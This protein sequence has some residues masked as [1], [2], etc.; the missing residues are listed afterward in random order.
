MV[1]KVLKAT[2]KV[3]LRI[4]LFL[5]ISYLHLAPCES[6]RT[7]R[8]SANTA[9]GSMFPSANTSTTGLT[10]DRCRGHGPCIGIAD[11]DTL[12][13]SKTQR[14]YVRVIDD[15]SSPESRVVG[16]CRG[17][18]P[19][20][21][22]LCSGI[23]ANDPTAAGDPL[24]SRDRG[25]SL[26]T[27]SMNCDAFWGYEG[28]CPHAVV[29][30]TN[31]RW[32]VKTCDWCRGHGPST[33]LFYTDT[34]EEDSVT[35]DSP[36][37]TQCK[38]YGSSASSIAAD[39]LHQNS[40]RCPRVREVLDD[41]I[42]SPTMCAR[43]GGRILDPSFFCSDV[44]ADE[45]ATMRGLRRSR[46]RRRGSSIGSVDGEARAEAPSRS[47]SWDEARYRLK[48]R[49]RHLVHHSRSVSSANVRWD[50]KM[51]DR[52]RGHSPNA[53]LFY[54]DRYEDDGVAT[55]DP[56]VH[57]C[58]GY[59][60]SASSIDTDMLRRSRRGCPWL[61]EVVDDSV[62]GFT[63]C[64][65][66][67]GRD[68]GTS[69]F[70][71]DMQAD[72][73]AS[74]RSLRRSRCR[75]HGP[76]IGSVD[77]AARADDPRRSAYWDETR[78]RLKSR[79]GHLLHHSRSE[80]WTLPRRT[81]ALRSYL[82][83][84]C[85][86]INYRRPWWKDALLLRA[87]IYIL[88]DDFWTCWSQ[89]LHWTDA[90]KPTD[91]AAI[92]YLTPTSGEVPVD[93]STAYRHGLAVMML[94]VHAQGIHTPYA[95]QC[96]LLSAMTAYTVSGSALFGAMALVWPTFGK[97]ASMTIDVTTDAVHTEVQRCQPFDSR[98]S[99]LHNPD[100][101][102]YMN[103]VL[104]AL[105]SLPLV[106][107]Y[108]AD[109]S[110]AQLI[111]RL[112]AIVCNGTETVAQRWVRAR[113]I[114][115][116]E[117]EWRH[118]LFA[119]E[120]A[121]AGEHDHTTH[122]KPLVAHMHRGRQEDA[123]EFLSALLGNELDG[124][125][126]LHM[127]FRGEV[128]PRIICSACN[129][130]RPLTREAFRVLPLSLQHGTG[131][132]R[133]L[134]EAWKAHC[135][136]GVMSDD[137]HFI[138]DCG[139]KRSPL[140]RAHFNYMPRVLCLQLKR[141]RH[142]NR[143]GAVLLNHSVN[144]PEFYT[145]AGHDYEL[146]AVVFHRGSTPNSG[147]YWTCAK[148]TVNREKVWWYSNDIQ[149]RRAQAPEPFLSSAADAGHSYLLFY[150]ERAQSRQDGQPP[151]PTPVDIR[152][153]SLTDLS[154]AMRKYAINVDLEPCRALSPGKRELF[155]DP[156]REH[157][158]SLYIL[159]SAVPANESNIFRKRL[160][161]V[162]LV[163]QLP[164]IV[165]ESP[166]APVV[167]I[168][169][170]RGRGAK[171]GDAKR[172]CSA[173]GKAIAEED[174]PKA[175]ANMPTDPLQVPHGIPSALRPPFGEHGSDGVIDNSTEQSFPHRVNLRRSEAEPQE[176]LDK[177]NARK[178]LW[179]NIFQ[180]KVTSSIVAERYPEHQ[181]WQ[182]AAAR[183]ADLFL[184]DRPTLPANPKNHDISF[185]EAEVDGELP[186]AHCA[187]R[188]CTWH[189]DS[190]DLPEDRGHWNSAATEAM[191]RDHAEHPCDE[192]LRRHVLETHAADFAKS[193]EG[194]TDSFSHAWELYKAG[195]S[196][197]E[198]RAIPVVGPL[199]DR[200]LF[201][202]LA[203]VYNNHRTRSLICMICAQIKLDTG[204]SHS[205]IKFISGT[206]F[207]TLPPQAL[208]KNCS[209]RTFQERYA[210]AGSPLAVY[211]NLS[212]HDVENVSFQEWMLTIHPDWTSLW[213]R[214]GEGSAVELSPEQIS[215][216]EDLTCEP[217]LCCPED[218]EC[219]RSECKDRGMLCPRCRIPVCQDCQLHLRENQMNP[220]AI[221]ND[222][223][224]GYLTDFIYQLR[225][226]WMEKT[227][228]SPYWTGLTLFSIGARGHEGKARKRHKLDEAMYT[229]Q[230]RIAFKGQLFSAP[231]D[232]RSVLEQIKEMETA[233]RIVDLPV[234]G[235]ILAKRVKV[236][237]AAG[238]VD[239]N[240]LLREATVR[241]D[242]VVRLIQMHKD[243]GH[244]DYTHL[245]MPRV[246]ELARSL[247]STDEPQIPS[248]IAELLDNSEDEQLEDTTDKAAT[249]AERVYH[250]A[251]LQ[252]ELA[253]S[254]P[255]VLLSQRDSDAQKN[256]AASR[257]NALSTVTTLE[258]Q[259]GSNL[260]QQF[261]TEY[262][263]RVFSLTLPRQVGGPDFPGQPRR[264]RCFDDAPTLNLQ[265]YTAMMARR[266]EAQVR[267]DWDL[268]PGLQSLSFAS[269]V[270]RAVGISLQRGV[271][272]LEDA[273]E[274]EADDTQIGLAMKRLYELLHTGE[275]VD[276]AG[277]RKRLN[278]DIS[279][280]SRVI[281]LTPLQSAIVRNMFFMSARLA[282]TR[283]V[284]KHIGHMLTAARIAY[285]VPIF[286]T[287][288]PSERHSGLTVHLTRYRLGDPG[289][290]VAT[291]ELQGLAG[292]LYPSVLASESAR[293]ELPE[294][295]LRRTCSNR[296]PLCAVYA[297]V[298]MVRVVFA[299]LYGLRMCPICPDCER[300]HSPCMDRYG[301]SATALGGSAGRADAMIGAVEAQKAEGVLHLHLFLF[302]QM[303]MQ[304]LTLKEIANMF[305]K[306]VLS[307][308]TWKQY[309]NHVRPAAYPEYETFVTEREDVEK[310]WPAYAH[311]KELCRPPGNLHSLKAPGFLAKAYTPSPTQSTEESF[312]A[313]G[314]MVLAAEAQAMQHWKLEGDIYQEHYRRRLQFVQSHMNNHIHP[315]NVHTGE[316]VPLRSCRRKDRP[317]ETKCGFPVDEG[318]LL[319]A[320]R[321]ICTCFADV[322]GWTT[323]GPRS[324]VGS[325]F[326]A[327]NDAM[328]N[329]G[330]A[331]WLVWS[332]DNGD[333][334]F[335]H[336]IP[337]IPETHE[338]PMPLYHQKHSECVSAVCTLNMLYDLQAA[339]S[340]AAGYFG[341]YTSK[342]QD[343]GKKELQRLREALERKIDREH[344]K[345]LPKA[346]QEYSK[347]LL[348][349]LEAKSTV[350][351]AVENLNLA[352]HG[353]HADML[354]AECIRTF[355]SVSFP[356]ATLLRREEVETGKSRGASLIV[357][358]HHA[359]GEG[360]R[361][362]TTAP[363]DLMYG[364]RGSSHNVDLLSPYEMLRYWEMERILIPKRG[365]ANPTA[366]WTEV[367]KECARRFATTGEQT[368]MKAGVHYVAT[369]APGRILLP[370]LAVLHGLRHRWCWHRRPRP[371]VP[372]WNFA[373][374]PRN[375]L[376][377]EENCRLLSVYM[378]P[379]TLYEK[380][381]TVQTPLLTNLR[382]GNDTGNDAGSDR[383]RGRG[384][385]ID[386]G[387]DRRDG[388]SDIHRD[389]DKRGPDEKQFR[390]TT[391]ADD[392]TEGRGDAVIGDYHR[393][394]GHGPSTGGVVE[395]G[396]SG[397]ETDRRR[398]GR[399]PGNRKTYAAGWQQYVGGNVATEMQRRY[400]QNLVIATTARISTE[401]EETTSDESDFE[402][403]RS[404]RKI[405]DLSVAQKTIAGLAANDEDVGSIGFG[406]YGE[407]IAL[408]RSLWQTDRLTAE[409]MQSMSRSE[410]A[411][412]VSATSAKEA[413]TLHKKQQTQNRIAPF[414]GATQPTS[415]VRHQDY[416][417][418]FARWFETLK[419]EADQPNEKQMTVIE[420]VRNR[421]LT[422]VELIVAPRSL[423]CESG[424][425]KRAEDA[426][427]EPL[428]ALC[429]GE[430]GTGKS[431]V[432]KWIIR[433]F[434]EVME[435][436]HG[437]EFEC[438]A[439]Q[440]RVAF[441]MG[442]STLHGA[443]QI[444]IG[445]QSYSAMLEHTDID[446]LFT[447]NQHLRFV[448]FDE[449]FMI[450]DELLGTF[451]K[452]YQEAAP[453]SES[454]RYFARADGQ[455]RIFGGL[456]WCMFGDMSQLPP[457]PSSSAIF[458][459]PQGKARPPTKTAEEILE[460][461][462]T[463]KD[464]SLN[465]FVELTQQQ[466]TTDVWFRQLL[467]E[468]RVGALSDENYNFLMGLPTTHNG[469]WLSPPYQAA[470]LC[471]RPRC[472]NLHV[473]WR[474][475]AAQGTDWTTM[476]ALASE[477]LICR[478]ERERRCR[479]VT[480]HTEKVASQLF[481][482]AP[483]VHQNNQPKYHAMLLRAVEHAKRGF[484]TP[485][486]VRWIRAQDTPLKSSDVGRTPEQ[487]DRKL[488][489]FLQ[490][491]DQRTA[492]IPGLFVMY[493][494]APVRTT[495]KLKLSSEI[496]VL[497][498]TSGRI[499]GWELH[500]ADA[501]T[502]ND[503]EVFLQ[504]IPKVVF[505]QFAKVKWHLDGMPPGLL[506]IYPVDRTWV[507]NRD[508]DARVTRRGFT[509]VN[510][511]A[512][513]AFM[514]QGETLEAMLADCGD[515][516]EVVGLAE[517]LTCY[518]IL[519]RI[520]TADGLLL[521]RAFSK[522]LFQQGEPPGPKCLLEFL[523]SRFDQGT[524]EIV[525]ED[526]KKDASEEIQTKYV[527]LNAVFER[528][529]KQQGT[530]GVE[531]I[532][533]SCEQ[534]FPA[535]GYGAEPT[536][537]TTTM[538][539]CIAQGSWRRCTA[540]REGSDPQRWKA[541]F[542]LQVCYD[543]SKSMR[544]SDMETIQMGGDVSEAYRCKACTK[545][546]EHFM[547]TVCNRHKEKKEFQERVD[548]AQT[549][550][551]CNECRTCS[552]CD[553]FYKDARHFLCNTRRCVRCVEHTCSVCKQSQK[554]EAFDAKQLDN[555]RR[556]IQT[557][558]K[559]KTCS[560]ARHYACAAPPCQK[561][562][563]LMP[564]SSFPAETVQKAKKKGAEF[565]MICMRC[566]EL[567]Y[568]SGR[569][570][571]NTY[572]CA[573]CMQDLGHQRFTSR[574]LNDKQ[575]RPYS[576]LCCKDCRGI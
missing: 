203:Y 428:R 362:W 480:K 500:A 385:S 499:V 331:A 387:S 468:C 280:L 13:R 509:L 435:W 22:P 149:Q 80:R 64:A 330:P 478:H 90:L 163:S 100:N 458:V 305:E 382:S 51:R 326:S 142:D 96:P 374:L 177:S 323:T 412:T 270:N 188:G 517:M 144:I 261:E 314:D 519:S 348:K 178:A 50:V 216:G 364:F 296:D 322:F 116:T 234:T 57:P 122:Y 272:K 88:S 127:L 450:P 24:P 477:C 533:S 73:N 6:M 465:F 398:Q 215:E 504:Y 376:P 121:Y 211:G 424:G 357:A 91:V 505:V 429:V 338:E 552:G 85:W 62:C 240:N 212:N 136:A 242:V 472:L 158:R 396:Y 346:F 265:S 3:E 271:R 460:A 467:N 107:T 174:S 97:R 181:R 109:A 462:W 182:D 555:N 558:L 171:G 43:R 222:N 325:V 559:C 200:R 210:R 320:P 268:L 570:G 81:R 367:G 254:R 169:T 135:A 312:P 576:S 28:R 113:N 241:Y 42:C 529:R 381:A 197:L 355:P 106:R 67:G 496:T 349:D 440:N 339:Q 114:V 402:Y 23:R 99:S 146:H 550:R 92:L 416:A 225:V 33:G 569:N 132:H 189:L 125:L 352:I 560:E 166:P 451:M 196:I 255:M 455:F 491:H 236:S 8:R 65:R 193:C 285:G 403:I 459:P 148:H 482:H 527:E 39:V 538:E 275:Y 279:K 494:G 160:E 489:R 316:R 235:E 386:Q 508:T 510:D 243:A 310:A 145:F 130:E 38:E 568:S 315:L 444:K 180:M 11:E 547:C 439:F 244:S 187:C 410:C 463:A 420:R 572:R 545:G 573:R 301:S 400:I 401:L 252:R 502:S 562:T 518:V 259:T 186:L 276:D 324:V 86:Y 179:L 246:R 554:A 486:Q 36:T 25:C 336:K 282:G 15:G 103:S 155:L 343:I 513:T 497:K 566:V 397:D 21:G 522:R 564:E 232:W 388:T 77:G 53:G 20:I 567:G 408:G 286:M 34:Y 198:R 571:T 479:L 173:Y 548:K 394:R 29:S 329:A 79:T 371:F 344:R 206:W 129:Q 105:W 141:W 192:L 209:M 328:L 102:C 52:C 448:L 87:L 227:V 16:L 466:R 273:H 507:V 431:R 157:L 356:A 493:V 351:T 471:R 514:M 1:K 190:A 391:D 291:P 156:I 495:E 249:P 421:L 524:G 311:T 544:R 405:G 359:R 55:G 556:T 223:F 31:S 521:L 392:D 2:K 257:E 354:R 565:V 413:V 520:K 47:G 437:V 231:M 27:V 71:S 549:I 515:V 153:A 536:D 118:L 41:F 361:T 219:T 204:G 199:I 300:T 263:P 256:V 176:T 378:R 58:R 370:D 294:Y 553:T 248:E 137:T 76:S 131:L 469:C 528:N 395:D 389:G 365:E 321:L 14:P 419:T 164:C 563:A 532:C 253:R 484:S 213:P 490:L 95:W 70:C 438:V 443:G 119:Y 379:W 194:L 317:K 82:L 436:K 292:Y 56:T 84:L 498:H 432:I 308:E 9:Y 94:V 461:F 69:F 46:C 72:G 503:F 380:D 442:G 239:L 456:N 126:P 44:H 303:A 32:D 267:W 205:A 12:S 423:R 393:C 245:D 350:R 30:D 575:K 66:R 476:Q 332:G 430:P 251:N 228:I 48:S 297:F 457:I 446:S 411:Y 551:R 441:A 229:S 154:T 464:N 534:A 342:M 422:E 417:I 512:S 333:I 390:N 49:T 161:I 546:K 483:Y 363:F 377:A 167:P 415:S 143:T 89:C 289:I 334:K 168:T 288:T 337:I 481:L 561:K 487:V 372:V 313:A 306:G 134:D 152:R 427:E 264:R 283:Q 237:V 201:Q 17:H 183:I 10:L 506:P 247:N 475:F 535:P 293:I 304:F 78:Y 516:W 434:E 525:A 404:D 120:L 399:G 368:V 369:T 523:R 61:R 540:C 258:I 5:L 45:N 226:T 74:V 543:C 290:R 104:Q 284:R 7:K 327:R 426:R 101:R 26:D 488:E 557:K 347:R 162:R 414:C 214:Y 526:A 409:E 295:D 406:E 373:K 277:H 345:P 185:T 453:R 238:L 537:L 418:R 511:F 574:A 445:E 83:L 110:R 224:I 474:A 19:S 220:Q 492:G 175:A 59:D 115:A 54:A 123:Q 139:S 447:K 191:F 302:V 266:V 195:I 217:L 172:F 309:I 184:R 18:G 128:Q 281:G 274:N 287:V 68:P 473:A 262:I 530:V 112:R 151:A 425:T 375:S 4:P 165:F 384:P 159:C 278:G 353:D 40:R 383:C 37:F 147:H 407:S 35:T 501:H 335:P 340:M 133:N 298:V 233:P 433:L 117:Y 319:K 470:M 307:L 202:R 449:I 366:E 124:L 485:R 98:P 140:H 93:P 452:N 138:C 207:F 341:G 63:V 221:M 170:K 358:V 108:C 360:L 208:R 539:L 60:P 230:E 454:S 318:E 531:W 260:L 218:H 542:A 269:Q 150:Q 541:R 111:G 250:E 75:G 299:N